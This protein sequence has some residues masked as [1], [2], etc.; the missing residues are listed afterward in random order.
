MVHGPLRAQSTCSGQVHPSCFLSFT[1]EEPNLRGV[2][3]LT[4]RWRHC[5]EPGPSSERRLFHW[6]QRWGLLSG[7]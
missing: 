3:K 6:P 5:G 4:R 2:N 7:L 1:I